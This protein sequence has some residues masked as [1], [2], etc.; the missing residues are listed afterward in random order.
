MFRSPEVS[1][2]VALASWHFDSPHPPS[3]RKGGAGCRSAAFYEEFNPPRLPPGWD[4]R[5]AV[6]GGA[7][8]GRGGGAERAGG[9]A[10]GAGAGSRLGA[11]AGGPG[12]GSVLSEL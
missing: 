2:L 5:S 6:R 10:G 12:W 3:F 11:R 7:Q 9:A 4:R 1:Q 8:A